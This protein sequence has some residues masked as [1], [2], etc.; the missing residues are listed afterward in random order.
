MVELGN[1]KISD[2]EFQAS[3]GVYRLP[4]TTFIDAMELGHSPATWR[5]K[6]TMY[7]RIKALHLYSQHTGGMIAFRDPMHQAAWGILR[8]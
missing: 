4:L 2:G 3:T 7:F 5:N 8:V 6:F 1:N